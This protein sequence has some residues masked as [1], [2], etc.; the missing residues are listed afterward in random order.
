MA[1]YKAVSK[2]IKRK[3]QCFDH[4]ARFHLCWNY[5]RL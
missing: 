3:I 4:Y 1:G 2:E 5:K